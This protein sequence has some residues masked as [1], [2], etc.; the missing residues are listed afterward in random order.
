MKLFFTLFFVTISLSGFAGDSLII[1]QLMERIAFL[2]AKEDGIFP[3]GSIPSYRMYAHNKDRFKADI[4]PFFT[5]LVSFTLLDIQPHLTEAQNRI[6]NQIISNTQ[7]VFEKFKNRKSNLPTYNFWPTDTPKIFPNAGWLNHFDKSR[8]LP[9]DMDDT[10]IILMAMQATDSIASM[11][12]ELMQ[13]HVNTPTNPV[14]NTFKEYRKLS[15][16]ST[17]FGKKMPT[18]FDVSVLMNVLYFVQKYNLKW[19]AADST[20]LGLITDVIETEKHIHHANYISH[21]YA[22]TSIV[23]Y[24]LSRLMSLKSIPSLELLKPKLISQAMN[25]FKQ[26][27]SFMEKILL[28]TSL[29][30]WGTKPPAISIGPDKNI[31]D[32]IED[33]SFSFFIANMGSIYPDQ[34][35]KFLTKSKLGTFYYYSPAFNNLLVLENLIWQQKMNQK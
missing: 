18:E 6:A 3:K 28:S 4:N 10:V 13:N 8:S 2:Q 29:L 11:V 16:Y 34:M 27:E 21:H 7:P 25:L 33:D 9:D 31:S 35:K 22:K 5:G 14:K 30:K 24:H 1:S 23:L 17:W 20:S 15:A 19:S 12:H 26:S 32:L